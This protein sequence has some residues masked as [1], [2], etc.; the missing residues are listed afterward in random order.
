MPAW[1]TEVLPAIGESVSVSVLSPRTEVVM[2]TGRTR[3]RAVSTGGRRAFAV[4]WDFSDLQLSIFQGW[5]EHTLEGGTLPFTVG[6]PTG[7][8]DLVQTVTATFKDPEYR[9]KARG[10]FRWAVSA[11]LL[12]AGTT[13]LAI[14]DYVALYAGDGWPASLPPPSLNYG[15]R[16]RVGVARSKE[17]DGPQQARRRF[18]G[19]SKTI[20]VVWELSNEQ[21]LLFAGF[22]QHSISRGCAKFSLDLPLGDGYQTQLVQFSGER[23]TAEATGHFSW[24]VTATLNVELSSLLSEEDAAALALFN[25]DIDAVESFAQRLHALVHGTLP[26]KLP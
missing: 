2:E 25:F 22:Y 12:V 11:T 19:G 4:A 13:G 21:L 8:A 16:T 23:Y 1:P 14:E 17:E 26:T 3:V 5:F 18:Y 15:F 6:L 9:T 10:P 7:S 20:S 24:R